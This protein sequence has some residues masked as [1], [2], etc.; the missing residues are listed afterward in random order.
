MTQYRWVKLLDGRHVLTPGGDAPIIAEITKIPTVERRFKGK[1]LKD[2]N[3]GAS[4]AGNWC[5]CGTVHAAKRWIERMAANS[6]DPPTI[7]NPAS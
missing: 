5:W 2:F 7:E 6:W 3:Q 4:R 1:L